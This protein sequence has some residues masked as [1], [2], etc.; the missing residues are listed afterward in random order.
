MRLA[1]QLHVLVDLVEPFLDAG[2]QLD[3][4]ALRDEVGAVD[5]H[6]GRLRLLVHQAHV[7]DQP[8][9]AFAAGDGVGLLPELLRVDADLRQEGVVLHGARRER[10]VEV[11]DERDGLLAERRLVPLA[12]LLSSGA[13]SRSSPSATR[14]IMALLRARRLVCATMA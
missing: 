7:G 13:S 8:V 11:V 14:S 6:A 12:R 9:G 4:L 10:A 1:A 5:A 2:E 3:V